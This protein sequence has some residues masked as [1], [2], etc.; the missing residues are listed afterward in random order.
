MQ[1]LCYK[2]LC[3]QNG[4]PINRIGILNIFRGWYFELDVSHWHKHKE[5]E[6]YLMQ[7]ATKKTETSIELLQYYHYHCMRSS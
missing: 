7:V 1:L 3:D 6:S 4:K 5:L 2:V